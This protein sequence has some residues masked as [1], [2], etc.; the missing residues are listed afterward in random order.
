[1]LLARQRGP[2]VLRVSLVEDLLDIVRRS[3]D[4]VDYVVLHDVHETILDPGKSDH[5]FA[6]VGVVAQTPCNV[7]AN[8]CLHTDCDPIRCVVRDISTIDEGPQQTAAGAKFQPPLTAQFMNVKP[9]TLH[10][11][12]LAL[13]E[14]LHSRD[15]GLYL[16]SRQ[17]SLRRN[18]VIGG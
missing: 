2:R 10:V 13:G 8:L 6:A 11:S 7:A 9:C 5:P 14:N 1:V 3:Y 12:E 15:G 4:G 17:N 18:R 16:P